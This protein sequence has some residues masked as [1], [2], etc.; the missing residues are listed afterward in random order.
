MIDGCGCVR[1][2]GQDSVP[3]PMPGPITN[4]A[5]RAA[6]SAPAMPPAVNSH[7]RVNGDGTSG[8]I[9]R[10]DGVSAPPR[11]AMSAR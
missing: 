7:R 11:A 8:W 1:N 3:L 6:T 4:T 2:G 5:M 9:G 10:P